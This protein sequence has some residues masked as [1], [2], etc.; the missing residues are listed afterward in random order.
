MHRFPWWAA[1]FVALNI[2]VAILVPWLDL[3]D[4][5][6]IATTRQFEA[7]S[8]THPL[9]LDE[10]GRDVLS[11]LL[12]GSRTSLSI[13]LAAA[14]FGCIVGVLFGMAGGFLRGAVETV[15]LRSTDALLCFP[16]LLLALLAV[17]LMG[18]GYST[19]IPLMALVFLPSFIRIAYASVLSIR[20]QDYVEAMR[21]L[22][23]GRVRVLAG[24][25]LP[26]IAGPVL[27]Q[28]SLA[29]SAAITLESGLSFIGLGVAPPTPTWGGMIGAGRG[30]MQNAPLQLL[31]PCLMLTI[32]IVS[33]NMLCDGLRDMLDP[34]SVPVRL[35]RRQ[36]LPAAPTAPAMQEFQLDGLDVAIATPD[37]RSIM[38][39][40]GVSFAVASGQTLAL[41]GE[42]GSGKSMTGLALTG[43]LPLNAAVVGGAA[44]LDGQELLRE[45]E[46][47]ARARRGRD[48]AMIFQDP[49]SSLNPLQRVGTQ[50]E[51]MLRLHDP[52]DA[53]PRGP[54]VIE[55][56]SRV[57]I[58]DPAR[59]ARAWPHE[60][61]G[62]MRQRVMI[63]M[64]IA[65]RPSLVIADEPTTALDV[66]IQAQILELLAELQRE[67][68]LALIFITHNLPVVA[69]M[70]D[71]VAV[72][73]AGQIVETG[74]VAEVFAD[75][76]HPYTRALLASAAPPEGLAP[77]GLPGQV[78][79]FNALPHGCRFAPR[80]GMRGDACEAAPPPLVDTAAGWQSRCIRWKELA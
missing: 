30:V 37:G 72:M 2:A 71:R 20:S 3:H 16:P 23:A 79:A 64:A 12:W 5:Y 17:T 73:Y 50:I 42:S 54:R 44:W 10:L 36:P 18:V 38:P 7:P 46:T 62:G 26:N 32:T 48:I 33:I 47:K 70:A 74:A 45:D 29:A 80:C 76:R 22:G 57:G 51:E 19:L 31:W 39:V 63:A 14:A 52:G 58:P 34:Q 24:T 11:R 4:P 69:E 43:L 9:G 15:I 55:L 68:G 77:Q 61:S 1:A 66:T 60:L 67:T 28:F 78:P 35:T 21:V 59:R 25:I 49:A 8:W 56:L 75:P 27:V 65:N 41:V 40:Q 53:P 6:A 13:A